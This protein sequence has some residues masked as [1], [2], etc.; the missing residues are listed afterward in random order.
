MS[1]LGH[2]AILSGTLFLL[3]LAACASAAQ[4]GRPNGQA[5]SYSAGYQSGERAGFDDARKGDQYRFTDESEY[6]NFSRS[7]PRD[8]SEARFREDFLRG[9]EAGYRNGY[10]RVG[11]RRNQNGPPTWSNGGGYARGR[12]V[13]DL[14]SNNGLR[15][16]YEAGANDARDRHDFDPLG[17]SRYRSGD[18]GYE[19]NYGSRD[20]YRARYRT[21]FREGY[22]QGYY[23]RYR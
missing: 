12:T 6:R 8:S 4:F 2:I 9:F 13:N 19:K 3:P 23:G 21:A 5:G 1:R 10:E 16:G 7:R 11:E 18:R 22:E 14:A 17:E 20:D 15:D